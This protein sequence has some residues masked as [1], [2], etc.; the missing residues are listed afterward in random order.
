MPHDSTTFGLALV[1]FALLAADAARRWRGLRS[2]A[3]TR[4]TATFVAAHVACV[5]V[6]RFDLSF[7]TM[8]GKSPFGFALFHTALLLVVA[9]AFVRERARDRIVWSAF[10]I[11]CVGALP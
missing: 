3:L 5:W 7:A 6:F 9:S 4:T 8:W 10:A 11:V 1:G 2:A